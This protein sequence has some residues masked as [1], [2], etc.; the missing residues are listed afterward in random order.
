MKVGELENGFK[1]MNYDE[2]TYMNNYTK[3]E[4][5]PWNISVHRTEPLENALW[6]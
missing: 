6:W 2:S 5:I 4:L 3:L 1:E